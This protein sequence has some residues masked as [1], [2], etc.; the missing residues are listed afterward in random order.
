MTKKG[1]KKDIT[2]INIYAPN[3]GASRYIKQI[4]TDIKGEIARNTIITGNFNTPFTSMNRAFGQKIGKA[5]EIL[6]DT[7]EKSD[8]TFFRTLHPNKSEYTFF[9]SAHGTFSRTGHIVGHK[10][11]LKK[12]ESIEMISSIF[13]TT[14]V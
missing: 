14:M 5:I 3:T 13:L 7:I 1:G 12:L 9:S 8:L 6:N 4:L 2:I 11:S 10:N